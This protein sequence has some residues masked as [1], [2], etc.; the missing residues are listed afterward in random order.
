M[1]CDPIPSRCLKPVS[2]SSHIGLEDKLEIVVYAENSIYAKTHILRNSPDPV[3]RSIALQELLELMDLTRHAPTPA[4]VDAIAKAL[5]ANGTMD[6][7]QAMAASGIST[8][9]QSTTSASNQ[10]WVPTL[11]VPG[12]L[13]NVTGGVDNTL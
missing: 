2:D 11:S 13:T 4:Q 5:A 9:S 10:T 1:V 12:G 8:A 6:I 7:G 3:A